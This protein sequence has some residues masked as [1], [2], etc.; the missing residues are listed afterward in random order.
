[1]RQEAV[2]KIRVA[3]SV[4]RYVK[5]HLLDTLSSTRYSEKTQY[6]HLVEESLST[7]IPKSFPVEEPRCIFRHCDDKGQ[8]IHLS[9]SHSES[10]LGA[11]V[12]RYERLPIPGALG[13][14]VQVKN[15]V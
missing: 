7:C 1:M 4:N 3:L 8:F 5:S 2:N 9:V 12:K 6:Q 11:N 10:I 15:T 13:N 14:V